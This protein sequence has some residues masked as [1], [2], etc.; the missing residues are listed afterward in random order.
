MRLGRGTLLGY[1]IGSL[2]TGLYSSTPSVLLLF[3]MTDTLGVPA[4]LA[5]TG[6]ALPRLWDLVADPIVG[7]WSD[8]T[9][10]RLGRR[11]PWLLAGAVLML[12]SYVA[13][14]N[15]PLFDRPWHSFLYVTALFSISATAYACFA[16]PYTAMAAEL[17]ES[18]EERVRVVA[19]RMTL[20]MTGILAGSALAPW[21]VAAFGG[22]RRGYAGMSLVVGTATAAAM[23]ATFFATRRVP[24]REEPA[25]HTAL[26]TQVREALANPAFASLAAM[27]LL[28]LLAIATLTAA[29]PYFA[30]H[31]EGGGE[32]DVGGLLL[33]LMGA[34][35]LSMP[36]WS[37][38]ARR[39]GKRAPLAAACLLYAAA[40]LA[41]LTADLPAR[42]AYVLMGLAFGAQQLLPF[43]MLTDVIQVEAEATGQRREG[44]FSGLWVAGEKAGLALGP[45]VVGLA[46]DASGFT[47]SAAGAAP[48][49]AQ[50]LAGIRFACGLVPAISVLLSLPLLHRHQRL[51]L[52]APERPLA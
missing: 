26:G 2:G 9:R 48:Q 44:L 17:S 33:L 40:S 23:L 20:A 43:A 49:S 47:E 18:P 27:Y 24:L 4:A 41:L 45:L 29:T 1:G 31:V 38:L 32:A 30:V 37:A 22:G 10:S 42:I 36:G 46:L 16:V 3:F 25:S 11:R 39:H 52:A 35:T 6:V 19:W 14:F 21:L 12:F 5:A 51:L 13:L 50:A 7:A 34:A 15:V 28:Q 8:R